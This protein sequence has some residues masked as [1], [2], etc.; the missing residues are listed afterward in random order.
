MSA[1]SASGVAEFVE[2]NARKLN[3]AID[4]SHNQKFGY[5]G[6]RTLYDRY[7]L[8]HPTRRQVIETP[9]QFWM[10]IAVALSANVQAA[11]E[12]YGLFSALDYVPSS[13]TLFNA[14]TRHEQLSSCFLLDSPEDSLEAIYDKYKDIA[15]LSKFSGGI[16]IAWHRGS[17]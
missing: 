1:S 4:D 6:L 3:A 17:L 16:G 8:K 14:G 12:L 13:P 10:R 5:F 2:A 9:Q 11:I 15:L 7:L